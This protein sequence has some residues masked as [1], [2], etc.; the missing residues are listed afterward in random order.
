MVLEH[1]KVYES[2]GG[3]RKLQ[4]ILGSGSALLLTKLPSASDFT[5][6]YAWPDGDKTIIVD[7]PRGEFKVLLTGGAE[8]TMGD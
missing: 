3:E 8:V 1:D 6:E 5:E 2:A 4:G 7:M